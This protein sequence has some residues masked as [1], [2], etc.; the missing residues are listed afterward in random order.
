MSDLIQFES[1]EIR[2]VWDEKSEQWYFAVVDVVG[3]LSETS[4]PKRYWSDLKRK[5]TKEGADQVY[6]NIV[7]LKIKA[8]DGRNR[9]TDC[10]NTETLFRIIQSIPSPKAE[11]FKMWLAQ[12]GRER[13]EEIENPELIYDR[14]RETYLAKGYDT[15]WIEKRIESKKIRDRLT[16]EWDSRGIERGLE[17]AIL[18]AEISKGAFGIKPSEHKEIKGLKRQ[19][20]RDHMTEAELLITM[21]GEYTT[22][23][24]AENEDAQGFD[25]NRGAAK[26][27]GQVAGN[28][29]RE[30]EAE[31]G[32]AIV[33]EDNF[34]PDG[35]KKSLDDGDEIAF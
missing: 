33:S 2:R 16:D 26:R 12:L 9:A 28:T 24:I 20:L 19:N 10:A 13:L 1:N 31:T 3:V 30:I 32:E 11:P 25:E 35:K 17:Y 21:L 27:G 29:R 8:S 5:L 14:M 6:E 22:R 15:E 4:N 23:T 18:T 34:L 7:R